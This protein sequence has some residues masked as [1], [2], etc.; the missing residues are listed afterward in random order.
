MEEAI[1]S[2][3]LVLGAGLAV[4]G[5]G[6][7]TDAATRNED[8]CHLDVFGFHQADEVFHDDID[9][10][11]VEAAMIAEGEEVKLQ[12]LALHHSLVGQ[13]ADANL[14]EV[15][16]TCDWA[17]SRELRAVEAH[18]IVVLRMLVLERL[19]DFRSIVL[20]YFCFLSKSFQAFLLSVSHMISFYFQG[21][22]VSLL[23]VVCRKDNVRSRHQRC[24][25][26]R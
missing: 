17:K 15:W 1:L 21:I 4:V 5:K 2:H 25:Y 18:P 19:Q 3:F 20:R 9:T 11:L 14:C 24:R 6:I 8:A 7:D 16:L 10:I 22:F 23:D 26:S 12:A 13:I